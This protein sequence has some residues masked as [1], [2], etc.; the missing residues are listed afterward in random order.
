MFPIS[1]IAQPLVGALI[2]YITNDLA[3]KMLFHPYKPWYVFGHRVPGTPGLIPRSK[4]RMAGSIAQMI[5]KK[6]MTEDTLKANLL[7]PGVIAKLESAIDSLALKYKAD[8]EPIGNKL[9]GFFGEEEVRNYKQTITGKLSGMATEKLAQTKMGRALAEQAIERF[10]QNLGFIAQLGIAAFKDQLAGAAA[11]AIDNM[12]ETKVGPMASDLIGNGIDELLG[13]PVSSLIN[14]NEQL[15]AT[16]K[17]AIVRIYMNTVTEQLPKIMDTI[18]IEKMVENKIKEMEVKEMEDL[19]F[20]I[21]QKEL[22][23]IVKLGALLGFI[24]G[25]ISLG[26]NKLS[27]LLG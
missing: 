5:S 23:Y 15:I 19:I 24:M 1:Y 21:M 26:I 8:E 2:G 9:A 11:E 7:S 14:G 12:V 10:S 18:D 25:F 22:G 3:I 17:Q 27:A 20:G 16:L 4:D 13:K 6:L